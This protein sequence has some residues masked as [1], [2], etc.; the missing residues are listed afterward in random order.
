MNHLAATG[1]TPLLRQK[2]RHG[3][4]GLVLPFRQLALEAMVAAG[5]GN[6][7]RKRCRS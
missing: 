3:N 2:L 1:N 5:H 4:A 6:Q 7:F